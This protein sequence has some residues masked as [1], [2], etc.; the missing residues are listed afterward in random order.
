MAP[1]SAR[2]SRRRPPDLLRRVPASLLALALV[3]MVILAFGN[4]GMATTRVD[5]NDGGIWVT[6]ESLQLAGHLN[7]EARTLDAALRTGT[8]DFDIAQ[9]R[10]TVTF[11]DA[12][13]RSI[14][15]VDPAGV[16]L[17]SATTLPEHTQAVQGGERVGLLDSAAGNLWVADAGAPAQA[18]LTESSALATDLDG[19]VVTTG[20]D[21]TVA[22]MSA[23]S[24]TFVVVAA[25]T[26]GLTRTPITG[27]SQTARISLTMVGSRPVGLD[28]AA[29]TLVLPDGTLRDLSGLGVEAGGVLQQPGP[30]TDHVLIATA[31]ALVSVPLS[32]GPPTELSALGSGRPAAPVRLNGCE[33]GA[34]SGSGAYVRQCDGVAERTQ[35]N[36]ES[37]AEAQ[38]VVFRTNRNL[39]V[40][41]DVGTGYLWLPDAN[42]LLL[43]DWDK[44]DTELKANEKDTESAQTSDQIAD[45]ERNPKN[46]EP[47]ATD[48]SFGVRP[49]RATTLD[50]LSNDSDSDGDILTARPLS[51]I[52]LGR[53]ARTRGGQALRIDVPAEATGGATFNYETNDGQAVDT[54]RVEVEV[55]P[56]TQNSGPRQRRHPVV[57]VG[58]NATVSYNLMP[59]WRDPDGD[60]LMLTAVGGADGLQVQFREE[61]TVT[62]RDLGSASGPVAL[63]VTLSDG[64]AKTEGEL[65]LNLQPQGNLAPVANG[66]FYVGR[67][68]EEVLIQ[69]LA[70]D[71][72]PNGDTLSLV[73]VSSAKDGAT[74]EPDLEGGTI[75]FAASVPRTYYLNY[76]VSDG[77]TPTLGVIRVDV[78]QAD[79]KAQVVAE[80]DVVLLPRGGAALAAPLD[81]DTDPAGGVL[82]IQTVTWDA[83][84]LKVTLVDHHLL[85]ITSQV[86]LDDPVTLT[87]TASNGASAA[88]AKIQVIPTSAADDRQPPV[89]QPDRATVRAGDIASASV[90]A[91]DRSPAGLRIWVDPRLSFTANPEVGVPFVTGNQVRIE[92]GHKPGFLRVAYT[93]RDSAGNMA[94]SNVLFEVKAQ[95][96]A[97]SAPRPEALTAWAVSG[98]TVRV[99]VNLTG[100]DPDGDSVTLVGVDQSPQKG[101]ALLGVDWLEYTPG[102]DQTGSDVFTYIVEDRLG[103]QATARVRVGIAPRSRLNQSP[104]AVRDTL[105][106]RPQRTL[107]VPVLENDIDPDGD[108]LSLDPQ[109]LTSK[110]LTAGVEGASVVLT[111]PAESGSSLVTYRVTDGRGGSDTGALTINVAEDAPKQAPQARDD[112]VSAD[113]VP[114]D[115]A[116]VLVDVLANDADPDGDVTE[117]QLSSDAPEVSVSGGRLQITPH[118]ER[119]LV[120]YT[121]SDQDGLTGKAVVSVPG[122]ERTRPRLNG[123]MVPVQVRAGAELTLDLHDLV[124]TREDRRPHLNDPGTLRASLGFD[125]DPALRNDHTIALTTRED[126]AGDTSVSFQVS[127]GTGEDRSA[128]TASITIPVRVVA[129]LNHPPVFTPTA[130]RVAVGEPA[131]VAD[132]AQMVSDVDGADPAT[133][134]YTLLNPRPE[135]L[136]LVL[137]GSRLSVKADVRHARG[138]AE[139]IRIGVDDGSGQVAAELPVTVLSSTRE[140]VQLTDVIIPDANAG[141]TRTVDIA[142]YAQN[143]FEPQPLKVTDQWV[144]ND[145]HGVSA[146]HQGTKLSITVPKQFH[147]P[148]T[149]GY[150]V[151]D[152]TEDPDRMVEGKVRLTVRDRPDPPTDVQVA[153][154]PPR[155]ATVTFTAGNDNGAEITSFVLLD[156]LTNQEYTCPGTSAGCDVNNLQLGERHAFK[157]AAVN[158]VGR[159]DF[160]RPSPAVMIDVKPGRPDPPT[161]QP[162]DG[163]ITCSWDPPTNEGSA[164]QRYVLNVNN[165]TQKTVGGNDTTATIGGL[166][167]GDDYAVTVQAWNKSDDPSEPSRSSSQVRPFGAPPPPEDVRTTAVPPSTPSKAKVLVTWAYPN[168]TNGRD[169]DAVRVSYDGGEDEISSTGSVDSTT[170]EVPAGGRSTVRVSLHTEGGWSTEKSHE[171]PA[172]SVPVAIEA[173]T[174]AATGQS[175]QVKV[176]GVQRRGGNGYSADDLTV[177]YSTDDDDWHDLGSDTIDGLANG[178]DVRLWF[179]QYAKGMGFPA[180]GYSVQAQAVTPYGPP[181]APDLTVASAADGVTFSWDAGSGNGRRVTRMVLTV[182]GQAVESTDLSGS[183]KFTGERGHR[184]SGSVAACYGQDGGNA[185]TDSPTV[186][187]K[188]YGSVDVKATGCSGGEKPD[189]SGDCHSFSVQPDADWLPARD[190]TCTFTSDIDNVSRSFTVDRS[191]WT[192]SKLRTNVTDEA[193]MKGWI[194]SRLVCG[195]R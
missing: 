51:Q 43:K 111:T 6:N 81:N 191:G 72:D 30:E 130:I 63:K 104:S 88:K 142:M 108:K 4:P 50:V 35:S 117:L 136:D 137:E 154:N 107:S 126:F 134:T 54:A 189:G 83:P 53:L 109:G 80:D 41:N 87:Y 160:S 5:V 156:T 128:L 192:A 157:V 100:I 178:R 40:V 9:H 61:G 84:N 64:K 55:H 171:F 21:G 99:P 46:T 2:G 103:K 98:Q 3:A 180:A 17:G 68:G 31:T 183:R 19:G 195:P 74:A 190:L 146:S 168:R 34:W 7:Y 150:R 71:T 65:N 149:I 67:V 105:L 70:N 39:I 166:T 11:Q 75:T 155:G 62:I 165:G 69:P 158:Q 59:D 144:I 123:S 185:C 57:K 187:A 13:A 10:D 148:V 22:A 193:T 86:A 60:P 179:R 152:A 139:V 106:V 167:N 44:V 82:V 177:Q 176:S 66:D 153:P 92:A 114:A 164:I 85:R 91:N 36:V 15:A 102:A 110:N 181:S 147:G 132:L 20:V 115:G 169:W 38:T 73:R 112:V 23:R 194:G 133:F 56:L 97:N 174:V 18:S 162:D 16:R 182:D 78:V 170:I 143:P 163:Q 96:A 151:M 125:G 159:S 37:L 124:I 118:K 24:G 1:Q 12:T 127:D 175:G 8:A 186:E 113:L 45:P 26:G 95:D 188:P 173:P 101:T 141:Q 14:A 47:V 172:V 93:V 121:I 135:K 79:D 119:R 32:G 122:T 129:S 25:D 27:L 161:C 140:L 48:D 116:P 76:S 77:P 89:L 33:Y 49:G 42:M 29:N 145:V 28:S 58:A 120:V 138:S 90:L 184:F 52:P 94:T 131:Q